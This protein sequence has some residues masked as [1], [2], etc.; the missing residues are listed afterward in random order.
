M[1]LNKNKGIKK[2]PGIQEFVGVNQVCF[3]CNIFHPNLHQNHQ[4]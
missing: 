2:T 3:L 4:F 1:R